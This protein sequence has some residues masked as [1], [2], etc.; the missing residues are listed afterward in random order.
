MWANYDYTKFPTVKV[1]FNEKIESEDDFNEFLKKWVLL[2]N[3]KKDFT[4]IFDVSNVSS[5][6]ISYVFKM[7]KFIK[8]IKEFPHQYLKKSL[9][10]VSN[11]YIKYLLS[12]VFSV[13]KPI[14]TVYIYDK[15]PEEQLNL[16]DLMKN[17]DE[18]IIDNFKIIKP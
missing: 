15:K 3:N 16:N 7:R 5:F 14:A 13:Q 6:N 9:I 1:T 2:Y 10:V 4:F 11:K 12:L 17:I 8:K 18:N